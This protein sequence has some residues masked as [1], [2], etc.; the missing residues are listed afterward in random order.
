MATC[1]PWC[2]SSPAAAEAVVGT[3]FAS[4]AA[5]ARCRVCAHRGLHPVR[6]YGAM[7]APNAFRLPSAPPVP[8]WPQQLVLCPS[9]SLVQLLEPPGGLPAAE[10]LFD[11]DFPYLASCSDSW[12]E[13]ARRSARE[14]VARF[15][16]GPDSRVVEVAS[17]DGYLLRWFREL[18]VPVLGIDPA[19]LAVTAARALEVETRQAFFSSALARSLRAEGI[20][21]DLVVANNV[22]AHVPDPHDLVAGMALL[23][24]PGG[25]LVIETHHALALLND[26]EFDTVY[27]EHRCYFSLHAL[28]GLLEAHGLAVEDV[29]R[30]KSHGGSLRVTA[31]RAP[32]HAAPAVEELLARE[33]DAGL[34]EPGAWARFAAAADARIAALD[35]HLQALA[36]QGL[37]LAAY[38]AAAKGTILLNSLGASAALLAY[39]VDRAPSKH[40]RRVPG[41]DLPVHPV[42]YLAKVPPDV[43]LLLPWNLEREILGQLAGFVDGGGRIVIPLP[44]LR[45]VGPGRG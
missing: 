24:R 35:A 27:H 29:Q 38:G 42:E 34:L 3:A 16:L 21:A 37:T 17:N 22:L 10:A 39:V 44:S 14:A 12:L 18:G 23:L 33:R 15:C 5:A 8:T 13:H 32:A 6:D 31:C 9:C 19:P 30:L 40:G 11:S 4:A 7:P 43:L 25:R 45:T 28:T 2:R 20:D 26:C 36:A 41:L 1:G